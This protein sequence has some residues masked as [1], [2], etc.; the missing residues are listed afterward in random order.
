MAF[1]KWR[2]GL[3]ALAVSLAA[4]GAQAFEV[5]DTQGKRHRL[6]DYKGK[7]VVVNFWA[8][9][10]TPCIREIPEIAEYQKAH[11]PDRA[12]VIGIAMDVE[13]VE[14][15]KQFAQ[16]VGHAYPL[17][18]EDDATEKQFGKVKGLPTTIIF[19]PAGKRAFDRAGTV[20]RKSL[21]D[22]TTARPKG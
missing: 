8:T 9:W 17:V 20:T 19:D 7:W 16:K 2:L 1:G 15:T 14:K 11:A 18:L 12:V 3:A 5:T 4:G 22:A 6:S 13:N 10:C 21:E